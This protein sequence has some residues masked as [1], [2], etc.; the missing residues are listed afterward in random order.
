MTSLWLIPDGTYEAYRSA[1]GVYFTVPRKTGDEKIKIRH[2]SYQRDCGE[3]L[4]T[5]KGGDWRFGK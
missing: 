1:S 3:C 2:R 4:I 5:I